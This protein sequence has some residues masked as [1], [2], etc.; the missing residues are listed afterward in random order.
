MWDIYHLP[1]K[2]GKVQ[3]ILRFRHRIRIKAVELRMHRLHV[4]TGTQEGME[5]VQKNSAKFG[6]ILFIGIMFIS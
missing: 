3:H 5:K 1:T 6:E 2:S 4:L